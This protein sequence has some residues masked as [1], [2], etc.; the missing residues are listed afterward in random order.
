MKESIC[1][2]ENY[3]ICDDTIHTESTGGGKVNARDRSWFKIDNGRVPISKVVVG[4]ELKNGKFYRTYVMP[5]PR[6]QPD[7]AQHP[8]RVT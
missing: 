4:F 8:A 7:Y 1:D 2:R 5:I 6:W 3:R